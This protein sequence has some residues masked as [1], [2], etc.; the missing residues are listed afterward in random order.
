AEL[1]RLVAGTSPR[2]PRIPFISNVTGDWIRAEEARDPAYWARQMVEPV[3]F[4]RGVQKVLQQ[5][6]AFLELGPGGALGSMLTQVAAARA[7]PDRAPV[8][9]ASLPSSFE[10]KEELFTLLRAM[11]K[12]WTGGVTIDWRGFHEHYRRLRTPLPTY[13]FARQRCWIDT[14]PEAWGAGANAEA[15]AVSES[16]EPPGAS[17]NWPVWRRAEASPRP[18]A[19]E[20]RRWLVLGDRD[21]VTDAL[22]ESL[23]AD[24][25]E[26]ALV[27]PGEGFRRLEERCW[28]VSRQRLED[29]LLLVDALREEGFLPTDLLHL[30][31]AGP[32]PSSSPPAERFARAQERGLGS[33]AALYNAFD[34][35]GLDEPLRIW[36]VATGLFPVESGD[37]VEPEKGTL[38]GLGRVLPQEDP[39]IAFTAI[40]LDRQALENTR[41]PDTARRLA[42]ILTA[43]PGQ[44]TVVLRGRHVWR[45]EF[46]VLDRVNASL[47]KGAT[48]K[49]SSFLLVGSPEGLV[50]DAVRHLSSKPGA[51]VIVLRPADQE[52]PGSPIEIPGL[53][54][55][56]TVRDVDLEDREELRRAIADAVDGDGQLDAVLFGALKLAGRSLT[57][58]K[59]IRYE[60]WGA[61][62]AETVRR[63]YALDAA[64][65]DTL[66]GTRILFSSL[67]SI[68]GGAGHM[69]AAS[70]GCFLDAFAHSSWDRA[71]PW[72]ALDWDAVDLEGTGGLGAAKLRL[73]PQA[74]GEALDRVLAGS[75]EAEQV[76]VC[77][78]SLEHRLA[79][80]QEPEP[81]GPEEE[82]AEIEPL[83]PSH[84]RGD[85]QVL[86]E[87]EIEALLVRLCTELLGAHRISVQDDFFELGGHSLVATRL[88]V[89]VREALGVELSLDQVYESPI[90]ADLAVRI[91]EAMIEQLED[92]DEEEAERRLSS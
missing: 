92:L 44:G 5:P 78:G 89:K 46:E 50:L 76:I 33:I 43:G 45:R 61:E 14:G 22:A 54:A 49:P 39:R 66:T 20:A 59:A 71:T 83:A 10:A 15:A 70:L 84:G 7:E 1:E 28:S 64:L 19:R 25:D 56:I 24:G 9:A 87:N 36:A 79:L 17:L 23:V 48:E 67:A 34:R 91:E 41:V 26:L 16:R 11:G 4:Y 21:G 74:V 40:D 68:L 32:L 47:P 86:P 90:L 35:A 60:Q 62:M 82:Q 6:W 53:G 85:G 30:W 27:V 65:S 18:R 72:I 13:P 8:V 75:V 73:S 29:Y 3:Q 37:R 2:S 80:G 52:V 69:V 51:R 38:L 55:G 81:G 42:E 77:A 58:L 31:S 88:L 63:L 12:L 57:P